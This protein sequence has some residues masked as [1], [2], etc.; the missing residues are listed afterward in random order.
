MAQQRVTVDIIAAI[1]R[2]VITA[3]DIGAEAFGIDGAT[4]IP[5]G[6]DGVVATTVVT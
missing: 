4:V 6:I 2:A 5:T 3:V 1:I